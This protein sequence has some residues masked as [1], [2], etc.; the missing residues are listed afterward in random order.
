LLN[1]TF[2]SKTT[3]QFHSVKGT[4]VEAVGKLTGSTSMQNSGREEHR[5]GEVEY[6]AAKAKEY[7]GGVSE[8]V[9]GRKDAIVGAVTGDS[10]QQAE[11]MSK[12]NVHKRCIINRFALLI[13]YPGNL[14]EEKGRLQQQAN[15]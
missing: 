11:G 12:Y 13:H 7:V 6:N 15:Q 5:A 4:V 3:G 2:Y 14:R 8:R 9:A 1:L 10:T